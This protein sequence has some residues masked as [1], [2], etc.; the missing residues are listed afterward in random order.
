M[1]NNIWKLKE[2]EQNTLKQKEKKESDYASK[3][4][5]H[6]KMKEKISTQIETDNELSNLKNLVEK[7]FIS[8]DLAETLLE[9]KNIT[10]NEIEEI[11]QKIDEIEHTQDV[12]KYLPES[13]RV[14]KEEYKKAIIDQI[15]RLQTL[16]KISTALTLLSKQITDASW[17]T[18]DIISWLFI[19]LDKNLQMIQENT[20]DIKN[21]LQKIEENKNPKTKKWFFAQIID[22]IKTI[23]Q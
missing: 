15:Q 23:I 1:D 8:S 17:N 13:L 2:Q 4:L 18:L 5:E 10:S 21:S 7:W 3:A 16:T 11:F 19:L 22:F 6:K 12:D 14:T 20:I 9:W